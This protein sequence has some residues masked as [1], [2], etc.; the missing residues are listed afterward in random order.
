MPRNMI[1]KLIL[2]SAVFEIS[3]RRCIVTEIWWYEYR[4]SWPCTDI[5]ARV[6]QCEPRLIWIQEHRLKCLTTRFNLTQRN[7]TGLP[8]I[9]RRNPRNR[10][11]HLR[12]TEISAKCDT[13]FCQPGNHVYA[14]SLHWINTLAFWKHWLA[15]S[16]AISTSIFFYRGG[17]Y[18]QNLISRYN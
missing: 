8:D 11:S 18:D 17:R 12:N 16:L 13:Y 3:I 10:A 14:C 5:V 15:S 4:Y 7:T 2:D 9:K 1:F 6:Q